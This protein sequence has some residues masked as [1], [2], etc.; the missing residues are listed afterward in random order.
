MTSADVKE[1]MEHCNEAGYVF[2]WEN[3][4]EKKQRGRKVEYS[5]GLKRTYIP[6]DILP[7][8]RMIV[9]SYSDGIPVQDLKSSIKDV[10]IE[11]KD[12]FKKADI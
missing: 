2:S 5:C 3:T 6:T 10:L 12:K 1:F 8:V 11:L 4:P 9:D 7:L